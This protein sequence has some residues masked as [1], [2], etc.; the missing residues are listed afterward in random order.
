MWCNCVTCIYEKKMYLSY[1]HL[2]TLANSATKI[3]FLIY[4]AYWHNSMFGQCWIVKADVSPDSGLIHDKHTSLIQSMNSHTNDVVCFPTDPPKG[5][6]K[7][8][9]T[10]VYNRH[11]SE[12]LGFK[13]Q[14]VKVLNEIS[15]ILVISKIYIVT[16][17]DVMS[18]V[19]QLLLC[20]ISPRA[21][22][23]YIL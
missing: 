18:G 10:R 1:C 12:I 9:P 21:H 11:Q 15:T 19:L 23:Q 17:C 14:L 2:N 20:T 16:L 4:R 7:H 22:S 5:K 13:W 6:C 8:F 3:A